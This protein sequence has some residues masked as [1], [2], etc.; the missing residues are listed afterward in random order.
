MEKLQEMEN[1]VEMLQV[2]IEEERIRLVNLNDQ[3]TSRMLKIETGGL[4]AEERKEQE[5]I[6]MEEEKIRDERIEEVSK[7]KDRVKA[8]YLKKEELLKE[9]NQID[10][11]LNKYYQE[12]R[13]MEG[14]VKEDTGEKKERERKM[15]NRCK[16]KGQNQ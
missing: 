11:Y 2:E 6:K 8:L 15:M 10:E 5:Q 13:D 1:K 3:I 9:K 7:K 4:C 12:M 16:V 14:V